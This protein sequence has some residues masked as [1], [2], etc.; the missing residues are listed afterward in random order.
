LGGVE[1]NCV[2]I[3]VEV[4]DLPQAAECRNRRCQVGQNADRT[5]PV[6]VE[7]QRLAFRRAAGR[8]RRLSDLVVTNCVDDFLDQFAGDFV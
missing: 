7:D 4:E 1:A 2:A 6:G 5:V 8:E 3:R